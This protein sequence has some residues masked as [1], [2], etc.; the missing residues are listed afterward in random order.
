MSSHYTPMA[1]SLGSGALGRV[2]ADDGA[3][4][5]RR[6]CAPGCSLRCSLLEKWFPEAGPLILW[7]VYEGMSLLPSKRRKWF[8]GF[9]RDALTGCGADGFSG[10]SAPLRPESALAW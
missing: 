4:I 3:D 10:D 1:V 6:V 7:L 8:I 2:N 5:D 9:R